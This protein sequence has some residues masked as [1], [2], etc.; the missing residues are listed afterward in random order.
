M[1][2]PLPVLPIVAFE[3]IRV[4]IEILDYRRDSTISKI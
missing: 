1:A 2:H 4:R 3:R